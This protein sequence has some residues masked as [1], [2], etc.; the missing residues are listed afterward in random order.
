VN[1]QLR[2]LPKII[3]GFAV[4]FSF[5][6]VAYVSSGRT[7]GLVDDSSQGLI[8]TSAN[9]PFI[10]LQTDLSEQIGNKSSRASTVFQRYTVEDGLS[11]ST[12]N[13]IL[14]DQQGFMWFGTDDGLNR[15]DGYSFKVYRNDPED[16][17]SLSHNMIMGLVEDSQ[18][19][20]WIGTYGGGLDRFDP[21]TQ[22]FTHFRHLPEDPG[23]LSDDRVRSLILDRSGV[24]W[25]ATH[26]GGVSALNPGS[27]KFDVLGPDPEDPGS[28]KGWLV[29]KIYEDREGGLWIGTNGL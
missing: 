26:G 6:C 25:I 5:V 29:D 12:I 18:G 14:Q 4:L 28:A 20:L 16:P 7:P 9:S 17:D 3:C 13:C 15:F 22:I 19:Y 27:S 11:H 21:Q 10:Y 8:S 1:L 23:S 24:L 2:V